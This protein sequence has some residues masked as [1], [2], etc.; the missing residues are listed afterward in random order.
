MAHRAIREY[1]GK[2]M[3]V[4][5]LRTNLNR[6]YSL[7]DTFVQVVPGMSLPQLAYDYPWLRRER[8]V[9]KVDQ[10]L[11]QRSRYDLLLLDASWREAQEWL[12]EH[13][14][15]TVRAGRTT[16][17][18]EY[19]LV[20]PFI[21]HEPASEHCLAIRTARA[22]DEILFATHGRAAAAGKFPG[23][24]RRLLVPLGE[25]PHIDDLHDE[26]LID[27]PTSERA[28][29]A[30]FV[31]MLF[32]FC[33]DLHCVAL[34]LN[35]LVVDANRVVPLNFAARVDS[36]ALAI[37]RTRWGDFTFPPPA[38]HHPTPEE[39][40]IEELNAEHNAT[41]LLSL[42][43]PQGRIW[44]LVAG[45][46]A[47]LVYADAIGAMGCA[48]ELANYGEYS[49]HPGE[50]MMCEYTRTLL[51]LMTREHDPRGKVLIIGGGI[52]N[53]TNIADTF[54]GIVR[55]LE[56]YQD[57][58]LSNDVSIYVRRGGP[59]Y[60]EGLLIMQE[61]GRRSGLKVVTAGPEASMTS[62]VS[63]ALDNTTLM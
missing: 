10:L 6:Q 33:I 9:V 7:A 14:G 51:D 19:F 53:L 57:R 17:T 5:W 13:R 55:A 22:G 32:T 36:A 35:P 45:A 61:F 18:L 29:L 25:L 37:N 12:R 16:S 20:E 39:R 28:L 34:E 2:R 4:R 49:G 31:Q 43:N 63:R 1:D 30:G 46:G 60:Q 47:A 50:G 52:A 8:L 42:L 11:E 56:E 26:L 27:I 44:M 23:E 59:E 40:A 62:I 15:K 54:K 21:P 41:C 3:L 24:P 48:A 58:L 38:G